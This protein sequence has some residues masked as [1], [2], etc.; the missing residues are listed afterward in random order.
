MCYF[1]VS[2]AL[3]RYRDGVE[4]ANHGEWSIDVSWLRFGLERSM[5]D[6]T[7]E[8]GSTCT[9]TSS[10]TSRLLSES[11]CASPRTYHCC[12]ETCQRPPPY[13][14]ELKPICVVFQVVRVSP[15]VVRPFSFIFSSPFSFPFFWCLPLAYP[16]FPSPSP[17][18][19][20]SPPFRHLILPWQI[21]ICC[22]PRTLS[23]HA[24]LLL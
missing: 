5:I 3:L 16:E 2:P 1:P 20:H 14:P 13:C 8:D 17:S 15:V 18:R 21:S 23:S 24:V 10:K 9:S 6:L 22:G 7:I 11:T 19:L 4:L 12:Q